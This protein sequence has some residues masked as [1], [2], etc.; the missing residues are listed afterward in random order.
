MK[1]TGKT[2]ERCTRC[3][4]PIIKEDSVWLELSQTDNCYYKDIPTGHTSQ[5][6]FPFGFACATRQL[7]DTANNLKH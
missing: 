6:T 1:K 7:L 4:R 5:G 2:N 3:N